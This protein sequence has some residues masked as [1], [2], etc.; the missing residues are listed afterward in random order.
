MLTLARTVRSTEEGAGTA[1][2]GVRFALS[3]ICV[4]R[5]LF[6]NFFNIISVRKVLTRMFAR[7]IANNPTRDC[8]HSSYQAAGYSRQQH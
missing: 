4:V 8:N 2:P 3:C 5:C 6:L 1:G 7:S